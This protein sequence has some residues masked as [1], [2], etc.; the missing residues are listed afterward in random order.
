M[1]Y[2]QVRIALKPDAPEDQV[3]H[4]LDLMRALGDRLDAV[5]FFVVGRDF[6]GE[7][8][9]GAMY[10]LKDIDAYR[11]YMYDPLHRRID[12]IGLPLAAGMISQDL[13]DD[14]DPEI[15][16]KIAQ[17]HRDRFADHPEL[18]GLVEGLGSY[19][20]SGVPTD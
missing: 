2:H 11:T 6:G 17:V 20:G 19:E 10:A 7:F 9:Y 16:D 15:G 5:E 12:A 14:P 18:L 13:T 8:H 3:Q 4:A 1:I